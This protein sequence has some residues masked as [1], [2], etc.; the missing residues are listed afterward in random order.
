[1]RGLCSKVF[2]LE[3]H[4]NDLSQRSNHDKPRRV[5]KGGGSLTFLSLC[6]HFFW[7]LQQRREKELKGFFFRSE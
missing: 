7:K 4:R 3:A 5:F 2:G 1:M 6:L